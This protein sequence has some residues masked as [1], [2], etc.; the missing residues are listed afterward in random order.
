MPRRHS[1][2]IE[3]GYIAPSAPYSSVLSHFAAML[4]RAMHD[5]HATL[6]RSDSKA[7]VTAHVLFF[8]FLF[9]SVSMNSG[10]ADDDPN[11][12]DRSRQ[13]LR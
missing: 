4:Q 6:A 13:G 12:K 10:I 1:D 11:A 9:C 5:C 3:P 8:L 7:R 2:S